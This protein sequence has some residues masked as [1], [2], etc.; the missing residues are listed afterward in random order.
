MTYLQ[1]VNAVLKRLRQ[2]VVLDLNASY[3]QL[4]G[5][6]V[7]QAKREVENAFRWSALQTQ[8][9]VSVVASTA[10]YSLTGF[11]DRYSIVSVLDDTND[12]AIRQVTFWKLKRWEAFVGD[13]G[14]PHWWALGSPDANSD[15]TIRLYPTPDSSITLQVQ[16]YVPQADLSDEADILL[17]PQWPVVLLAL[18]L[19]KD[20][21]GED[22]G[23]DQQTVRSRAQAALNEEI[24]RESGNQLQGMTNDWYVADGPRA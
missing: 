20:E 16:A 23:T 6:L 10:E 17:V 21:R 4:I 11:G 24:A 18:A 8:L 14:T 5:E 1:L 2:P 7:N 3:S 19:A 22:A 9:S 13:T 12:Y 15:P